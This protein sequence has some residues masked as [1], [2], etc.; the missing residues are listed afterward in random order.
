MNF[1]EQGKKDLTQ[2]T[3]MEILQKQK[4]EQ[5]FIGR[6]KKVPGHTMFSYNTVTR[7]IKVAPV[8]REAMVDYRTRTPKYKESIIVEKDCIY[9]QALNKKN[10]IKVLKRYGYCIW[11]SGEPIKVERI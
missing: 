4:H 3:E 9:H 7:E 5:V 8:K 10:F 1:F 2:E 11:K 6:M